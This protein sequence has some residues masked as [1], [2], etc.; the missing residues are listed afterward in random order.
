MS[1]ANLTLTHMNTD[2]NLNPKFPNWNLTFNLMVYS[3]QE[4]QQAYSFNKYQVIY[5]LR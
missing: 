4:S 2:P 1:I 3:K 5:A